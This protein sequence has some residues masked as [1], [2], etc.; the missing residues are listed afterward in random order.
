M[1]LRFDS[2]LPQVF[3][4]LLPQVV[5]GEDVVVSRDGDY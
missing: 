1:T 5:V 3:G 4:K 2:T